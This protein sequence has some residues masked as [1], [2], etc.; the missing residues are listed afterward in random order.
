MRLT[1][2]LGIVGLIAIFGPAYNSS[3]LTNCADLISITRHDIDGD[4]R[5]EIIEIIL[6]EGQRYVDDAL[7]CGLGDKWEGQFEIQVRRGATILSRQS[8]NDLMEYEDLFFRAPRFELVLQ[9]Y[10]QDGQID[11]N[12]GQYAGCN[13]CRYSLFTVSPDGGI[14]LLDRETWY[15]FDLRNSTDNI[16]IKDKLVGFEYYRQSPPAYVTGWYAWNGEAFDFVKA[17]YSDAS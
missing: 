14:S 10:N 12:L 3:P 5:D 9:D 15:M 8:L 11:F 7:W 6:V 16:L 2:M 4:Q 13:G 17:T 1:A